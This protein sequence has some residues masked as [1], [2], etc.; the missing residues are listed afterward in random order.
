MPTQMKMNARQLKILRS[1]NHKNVIK[2]KEVV[3]GQQIY[4]LHVYMICILILL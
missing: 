2:I 4:N 3:I 1:F